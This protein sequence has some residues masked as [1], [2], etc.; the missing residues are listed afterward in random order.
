MEIIHLNL[1]ECNCEELINAINNN[2]KYL[3]LIGKEIDDINAENKQVNIEEKDEDIVCFKQ[4]SED[5]SKQED[6]TSIDES[7]DYYYEMVEDVESSYDAS[8][9]ENMKEALPSKN[10]MHYDDILFS[11]QLRLLKNIKEIEEFLKEEK[12]AIDKD[13]LVDLKKEIEDNSQKIDAIKMIKNN[14]NNSDF[15]DTAENNFIFVPTSGGNIRILDE[16]EN[17]DCE[18]LDGFKSLISSIKDG[19]FKNV[20]RFKT[21]NNKNSGVSEVKD[22]KIRVVFDRVGPHEYA[23]IT[24]FIKKSDNDLGYLKSLNSKIKNYKNIKDKL[25]QNL[26]NSEFLKLQE[27]YEA[28]LNSIFETKSRGVQYS[29]KESDK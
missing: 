22:Y 3:N 1:D 10:S 9:Y 6:N 23:L 28:Q 18:Y 15:I 13:D 19:S 29:K 24:A 12:D 2:N 21:V 5:E 25:K 11:I 4:V 7:V 27:G 20:K 8:F 16:L 17:I 26:E 14:S